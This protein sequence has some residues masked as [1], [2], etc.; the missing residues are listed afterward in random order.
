ML[1]VWCW[2]DP[3]R[4]LQALVADVRR[5]PYGCFLRKVLCNLCQFNH[6]A[7]CFCI[8]LLGYLKARFRSCPHAPPTPTPSIST[9]PAVSYIIMHVFDRMLEVKMN[10]SELMFPS[11][12]AVLL[13]I[14]V[15]IAYSG[16]HALHMRPGPCMSRPRPYRSAYA[17]HC[18]YELA[19]SRNRRRKYTSLSKLERNKTQISSP[20]NITVWLPA[21][22]HPKPSQVDALHYTSRLLRMRICVKKLLM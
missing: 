12:D 15:L 22:I 19:A 7:R 16:T 17:S 1:L 21:T 14:R 13:S 5:A 10:H 3:F 9:V 20:P 2:Q 6:I 8:G 4:V 18:L 11:Q